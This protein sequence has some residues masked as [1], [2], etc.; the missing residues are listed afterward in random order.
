M[1]M[2]ASVKL[3]AHAC[4][5]YGNGVK[6]YPSK[7]TVGA[8]ALLLKAQRKALASV[9]NALESA[10]LPPLGWYDALLELE[11]AGERGLRPFELEREMLLTQYNVSR[12]IDRISKAGYVERLA[13]EDDGRGQLVVITA[14]GKD[15]RRRMWTVY[16]P[17][18]QVA[19]GSHLSEREIEKLL[20]LLGKLV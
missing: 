20:T 1:Q 3:D 7:T 17:A 2:N 5:C 4:I 12:L 14:E 11:R 18:I 9:E 6:A 13:C 15:I 16:G 8:W 19:L 10:G